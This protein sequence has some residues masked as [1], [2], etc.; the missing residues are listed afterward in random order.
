MKRLL[1]GLG[2]RRRARAACSA[3]RV[4][5]SRSLLVAVPVAGLQQRTAR[6][7]P[8][9][10]AGVALRITG[11]RSPSGRAPGRARSR[12]PGCRVEHR[13]TG[14]SRGDPAGQGQQDGER[15]PARRPRRRLGR[16]GAAARRWRATTVPSASRTA[17]PQGAPSKRPAPSPRPR[18]VTTRSGRRQEPADG[19]DGRPRGAERCG[20][21]PAGGDDLE[22]G[23]G[24]VLGWTKWPALI[25][26]TASPRDWS[27]SVGAVTRRGRRGCR[28]GR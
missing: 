1:E 15:R 3:A 23:A 17:T 16:P 11:T 4:A 7:V 9:S 10:A 20:A 25:G 2:Q 21:V 12:G 5:T 6:T 19:G 13:R 14:G 22:G 28:R 27:T 24:D 8:P 26:A 18:P